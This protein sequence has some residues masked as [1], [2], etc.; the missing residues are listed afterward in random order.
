MNIK[1]KHQKEEKIIQSLVAKQ[2]Q[3]VQALA[4]WKR[5]LSRITGQPIISNNQL[6]AIYFKLTPPD[7]IDPNLVQ[8]LKKRAVRTMSGVAPVA[9]LTK[10]YPCP[11][12][13]RYCP[14][15]VN[16]PT[17]YLANE[18][19]VMRARH[20]HYDPIKQIHYRLRALTA[21]G[22]QPTKI[23]LIIIGGTWSYLPKKYQ[24]WY[25]ANCYAAAN[26]YGKTARRYRQ[27]LSLDQLKK[28][29]A[30]EQTINESTRYR[31][32]GLTLETRPDCLTPQELTRLRE[33]GCTRVEIG[34]Q[35]VDDHILRLNERT[36]TVQDI[37]QATQLLRD[38]G[39]KITYHI[40][41]ALPGSNPNHDIAMYKKLFTDPRFQPDQI[42][43]YPTVVVKGS[44]LYEDW[45]KGQYKPYSD[46]ELIRVIKECK[47]ATPPYVRIVR[48]IRD[49]PKESIEAGNK[50]TN[51][52]QIIQKQGVQCQ[53]IR[54]REVK[55]KA[56]DWSNL[57]LIIRQYIAG[58]GEEY[59]LSWESPDQSTIFGFCRLRLPTK[60]ASNP[61]L[62]DCALIRELHVYGLLQPLGSQG[63]IQHRG[64]G[65][66]L[67]IHAEKIAKEHHYSKIAI[68]SG[69]GVRN[70]YRKFGYYLNH[71]YLVK[72]VI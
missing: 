6:L 44:K 71:T 30:K 35:I 41:P 66:K 10:P 19:A 24:Y 36:T 55:D 64:L 37:A 59:F 39:F 65:E 13:C 52:R 67:L 38:W 11:G 47:A 63:Q 20:C 14:Q 50:I 21:N 3:N 7:K 33:F 42:K 15:Q 9:I 60:P 5:Q 70:Y 53:C 22:H 27:N 49:I 8:L 34:V 45:L 12:H 4:H 58:D 28:A 48:L 43:F 54:C 25:I 51:L 72:A 61:Y 31:I 69:V 26:T 18:P 17:S 16:V 29:I 1:E 62:S 68:I 40:M 23:E 56:V 32:V 46:S 2:P 57:Q